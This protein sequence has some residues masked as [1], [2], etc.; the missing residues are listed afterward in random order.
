MRGL[1][2]AFLVVLSSA[3]LIS[4]WMVKGLVRDQERQLLEVRAAEVNLVLG[5]MI[6]TVQSR[7][8]LMGAV[9]RVTNGSPGSFT[10]TATVGDRTLV[11]AAL[12][13]AAPEGL[14]VE[15]AVGPGIAV[16]Q[17][18]TGARDDAVRRALDRPAIVSTPVMADGGVRTLGFALGPPA[19]PPGTVVYRE[20]VIMPGAPSPATASAPFSELEGSLYASPQPDPAQLVLTTSS[21]DRHTVGSVLHRPFKVGDGQ[22]HLT[23]AAKKPLVGSLVERLPQVVVVVGLLASLTIFA[24]IDALAR[25]RDYAMQLVD[26]RTADLQDLLA[27][28]EVAQQEALE[29]SR[30]KSQFLANTSHEIR[31]P[32]TV[33]LGMNELLL[34]T[35]LD[36]AQRKFAEG[37]S[38]A[39]G[40]LLSMIDDLLDF[41]KIEAGH[42]NLEVTDVNVRSL[43]EDVCTFFSDAART[44]GLRL[45]CTC[46]PDV[47]QVVR[48]DAARL[49]Q[50]LLN[51][52]SNAV[53]FTDAGRVEVTASG[54]ALPSGAVV[55][56]EVVD[57]GIGIAPEDQQFLFRPFSQIDASTTRRYGGTGLGLAISSQLVEAMGGALGAESTPG[58]GS[59]FWF[60]IP[61]H[62]A[63]EPDVQPAATPAP[64]GVGTDH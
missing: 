19:T 50:I 44:K 51:L 57:T 14:V 20:V 27:S 3:S 4:A 21:P 60:E 22:W 29:A 37:V 36:P 34:E 62:D 59:T 8:T 45:V 13:R 40:R 1:S 38:R 23:V 7:L 28:L 43:V 47:P 15:V 64:A 52:A 12:L 63:P 17:T 49:R 30:L 48:G 55:R 35:E 56:F 16:G 10:D 18:F 32:M 54:R 26:E 6:S 61:V 53:K 46:R 42:L 11:G 41:S 25:R 24:V 9:A 5:S 33:I 2:L 31:T 58:S 39:S